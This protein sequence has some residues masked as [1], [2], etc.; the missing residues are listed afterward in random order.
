MKPHLK[1][2]LLVLTLSV[3]LVGCGKKDGDFAKRLTEQ[4]T[5]ARPIDSSNT[6]QAGVQADASGLRVDFIDVDAPYS[7]ST[8]VH[9]RTVLQ[10]NDQAQEIVSNHFNPY[11][12]YNASSY[13]NIAVDGRNV[14]I[15]STCLDQSCSTY[16][17]LA[18]ITSGGNR[19]LQLGLKYSYNDSNNR[20]YTI[21]AGDNF[22]GSFGAFVSFMNDPANF[23]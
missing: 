21:R 23:N 6:G 19:Q 13:G 4:S 15:Q 22:H 9:V 8:G 10:I 18:E 14:L 2:A 11:Y 7:D 1:I 20:W 17:I 16:Y 3:G 12:G 5:G